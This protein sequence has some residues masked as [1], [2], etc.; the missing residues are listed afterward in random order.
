MPRAGGTSF[1]ILHPDPFDISR[2]TSY[3]HEICLAVEFSS[4][5][6]AAQ[7]EKYLVDL[8]HARHVRLEKNG[9]FKVLW[10]MSLRQALL[11]PKSLKN[12]PELSRQMS[13]GLKGYSG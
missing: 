12:F 7:F 3:P 4:K 10:V 8:P 11:L 6:M 13:V 2:S 1:R 5:S 9:S